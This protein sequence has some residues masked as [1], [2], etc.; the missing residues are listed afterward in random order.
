MEKK[1]K[2]ITKT[3]LTKFDTLSDANKKSVLSYIE[4]LERKSKLFD[5]EGVQKNMKQL[6]AAAN[7][8]T[9]SESRSDFNTYMLCLK[10][11][12][13]SLYKLTNNAKNVKQSFV[14]APEN[15]TVKDLLMELNNTNELLEKA[16]KKIGSDLTHGKIE[17]LHKMMDDASNT[18][19][20]IKEIQSKLKDENDKLV[21]N[22]ISLRE[23]KSYKKNIKTDKEVATDENKN[24]QTAEAPVNETEETN[25]AEEKATA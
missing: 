11:F 4:L 8:I 25:L 17:E 2:Q 6:V 14:I 12:K 20:T 10:S 19:A 16:T 24:S 15:E 18:I 1:Q 5:V 9:I 7:L 21:E 3:E 22:G 23:T 13:T